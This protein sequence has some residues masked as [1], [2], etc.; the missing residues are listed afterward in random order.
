P[1]GTTSASCTAHKLAWR[2]RPS[3]SSPT[4]R[5]HF[6]SPTSDSSSTSSDSSSDSSERPFES[7]FD[8]EKS[9]KNRLKGALRDVVAVLILGSGRS[10]APLAGRG[11]PERQGA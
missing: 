6:T 4:S 8:D 2:R 5:R 9:P 3:S 11:G 7:R 10:P 1:D